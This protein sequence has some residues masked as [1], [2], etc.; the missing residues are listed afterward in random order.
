MNYDIIILINIIL[1]SQYN[2]YWK[3]NGNLRRGSDFGVWIS[4][5]NYAMKQIYLHT[6]NVH[7]IS[8]RNSMTRANVSN[9]LK[10]AQLI[11]TN[12]ASSAERTVYTFYIPWSISANGGPDD[13][14]SV[15]YFLFFSPRFRLTSAR[16]VIYERV[17]WRHRIRFCCIEWEN[18]L[19]F[20]V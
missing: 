13:F 14:S 12:N 10:S 8:T 3:N 4:S 5:S 18:D 15:R 9:W 17:P 16:G 1:F 7:D 2:N 6:L 11:W 19:R 20:G